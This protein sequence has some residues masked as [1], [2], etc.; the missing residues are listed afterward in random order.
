MLRNGFGMRFACDIRRMWSR[1]RQN[2]F[3]AKVGIWLFVVNLNGAIAE[4][5]LGEPLTI[6]KIVS[7]LGDHPE[8][9]TVD[10]FLPHLPKSFRY[11]RVFA[12]DSKSRQGSTPSHPRTIMLAQDASF[13]LT[14]TGDASLRN[15]TDIE[16][17]QVKSSTDPNGKE[18]VDFQFGAFSFEKTSTGKREGFTGINPKQ[19]TVCHER[20]GIVRPIW[21]AN[22][23]WPGF[24]GEHNSMD[25]SSS[26]P[27]FQ[28]PNQAKFYKEFQ[29]TLKENPGRFAQFFEDPSQ[30]TPE[31]IHR[32]EEARKGISTTVKALGPHEQDSD[33]D[34]G[35]NLRRLSEGFNYH[36]FR[37]AYLVLKSKPYYSKMKWAFLAAS[38]DCEPID[39]FV[40]VEVKEKMEKLGFSYDAISKMNEASLTRLGQ[41]MLERAADEA[42][43]VDKERLKA[44]KIDIRAYDFS[45]YNLDF[46]HR[47]RYLMKTAGADI[48]DWYVREEE[49]V[50][51][52]SDDTTQEPMWTRFFVE[53]VLKLR[54]DLRSEF[55]FQEDPTGNSNFRRAKFDFITAL[56]ED[57]S[58]SQTKETKKFKSLC[59]E[60]RAASLQAYQNERLGIKH[61]KGEDSH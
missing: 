26:N 17:F 1:D 52:F 39:S 25:F 57:P 13:V 50:G 21:D 35:T 24:F 43:R 29:K 48:Y 41:K 44:G 2:K 9:K 6:E 27:R 20:Q 31:M 5:S 15:G 4:S 14:V 40:P 7:Y 58:K 53:D 56:R 46:A 59:N 60:L 37:R 30:V 34:E 49:E 16:M 47:A 22:N 45:D 51:W 10:D 11:R 38:I 54:P 33:G 36:N 18:K 28:Y 55:V 3:L 23:F 19:C 8:I 12:F 32:T 61:L 42:G